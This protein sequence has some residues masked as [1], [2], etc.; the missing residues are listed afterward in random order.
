MCSWHCAVAVSSCSCSSQPC[1]SALPVAVSSTV[2]HHLVAGTAG[3]LLSMCRACLCGSVW[4]RAHIPAVPGLLQRLFLTA[5]G[6]TCVPTARTS[7]HSAAVIH[8]CLCR[9][10]AARALAAPCAMPGQQPAV[11]LGARSP[12]S[13]G[14]GDANEF[15]YIELQA[16]L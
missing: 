9:L 15:A 1:C 13:G 11:P 14:A 12:S 16:R 3:L 5:Q 7:L 6:F 10:W 4:V 8:R 2:P